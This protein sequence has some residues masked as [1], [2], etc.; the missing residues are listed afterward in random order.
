MMRRIQRVGSWQSAVGGSYRPTADRRPPTGFTIAELITVVAI[1]AILAAVAMPVAKLGFRRQK[2]IELRERLRK[3]TDA[4]DRYHELMTMPQQPQQGGTPNQ[5]PQVRPAQMQ[6]LGSEN[7]PKDFDELLKGV[8][9]SDG[10][11]VHLIRERDL[12]DPM[13]GRK[14]WAV[15]STQDD[16]ESTFLDTCEVGDS[17]GAENIYEVHSTSTAMALDGKTRYNE[18]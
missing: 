2:E 13:T 17:C 6:A 11:T 8:K 12:I 3:I 10:R 7:Y 5:L 1:I 4:I 16:P 9:M 18:W 14:E 15:L